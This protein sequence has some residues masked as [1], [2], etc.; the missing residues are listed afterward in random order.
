MELPSEY[1]CELTS[2]SDSDEATDQ[3]DG[4][5]LLKAVKNGH[6]PMKR[7]DDMAHR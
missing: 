6:V 5:T 7:L 3:V 2:I 4:K 1:Y